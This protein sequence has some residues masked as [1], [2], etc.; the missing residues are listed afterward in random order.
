M[1][2]MPHQVAEFLSEHRL[3]VAGVSR[4]DGA[5]N[6]V[7]RKL[8]TAGYD[9]VAV[10]PNAQQVEGGPCYPDLRSVPAPV[11]GL[12]FAGHPRFAA[13]LVEQCAETGVRRIWFH[14]SFGEGSVSEEALRRCREKGIEA[15]VGGCPLMYCPP[16]DLGHRC[17]CWWLKR[18]GRVPA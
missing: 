13:D 2:Q 3:A 4:K 7:F 12:V 16:V 10:N 11:A 1:L 8:R 9:V 5:A 15:I 17:M 18:R 14:R 6:A